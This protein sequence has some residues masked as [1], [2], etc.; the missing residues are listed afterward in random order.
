MA[1]RVDV[2]VVGGGPAGLASA[3]ALKTA[4]LDRVRVLERFRPPIDKACGEGLMPD[5]A[6]VLRQLG[7]AVERLRAFP[8]R[9]IR[10]VDGPVLVEGTFPRGTGLGIR[11]PVLHQALID[12]A[13]EVGV[14]LAWHT[15]VEALEGDR[16]ETSAGAITARWIIAADGLGSRL[17]SWAGLG[18]PA[19]PAAERRFGVRRHFQVEPWTDLVEVHWHDAGEA[20][21][22]P[23]APDEVGV[24][25][26]WR[27]GPSR[28]DRML[29]C[30]P[31]LA[32]RLA[33]AE[34]VSK[35]RGAGPLL[36]KVRRVTRGRLALVGDASGYVDAITGEGM[37]LA[38]HQARALAEAIAAGDLARYERAHRRIGRLPDALTRLVLALERRPR[39]RRRAIA[40]LA[41][42]PELFSR[43][44]GVHSR[45]LPLSHVGLP[46]AAR[47]AWRLATG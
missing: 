32:E 23:V 43:L 35:D 9:G 27:G 4:G 42:E 16:L 41:A 47:L 25:L 36:Q 30:F 26:L 7:V 3:I 14:E 44:L 12:R 45:S 15:R 22:T 29:P 24:A 20:Y 17:R 34:P 8:F 31:A 46:G 39:L 13:L 10:Y 38:F 2:V 37:S 19:Q 28:F 5:G 6:E 40:A 11:R 33:G 18:G 21:V 1:E